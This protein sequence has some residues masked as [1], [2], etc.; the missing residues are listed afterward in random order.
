MQCIR[1]NNN[2]VGFSGSYVNIP[3]SSPHAEVNSELNGLQDSITVKEE[4]SGDVDLCMGH[5]SIGIVKVGKCEIY[6]E[7]R[8]YNCHNRIYKYIRNQVK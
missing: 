7:V 8:S 2:T 5:F 1:S 6:K 3:T 4:R